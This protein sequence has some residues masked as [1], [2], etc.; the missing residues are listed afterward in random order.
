MYI[1]YVDEAGD[2]GFPKFSS[3]FFVL[4]SLYLHHQAWRDSFEDIHAFR[5]QLRSDYG[6]PV[7]E[8]LHARRFVLNKNPYRSLGLSDE[9]RVAV[10]DLFTKL[11][12]GLEVK[13]VNVAIIK[14]KISNPEYAVLDKALTYLIQ[15]IENDLFRIDPSKRFLMLCDP[16]R[17][18]KMRTTARRIQRINY[19][20]SKFHP[21]SYRKE[22]KSLIEDPLQKDSKESYFIQIADLVS[23]LVYEYSSALSGLP[24]HGR[25]PD[26]ITEQKVREW[27]TTLVPVLNLDATQSDQFGVVM[28]PK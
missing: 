5:R 17:I 18:A 28:Y 22:I 13:L 7:K 24:P 4:T 10:I 14:D 11:I 27:L 6:F 21:G 12:A 25:M 9:D 1:A 26:L 20:P 15:R 3:P 2:D 23:F 8:E 19:I 16:G